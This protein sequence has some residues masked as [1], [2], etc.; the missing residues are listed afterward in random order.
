MQEGIGGRLPEFR[1]V[2]QAVAILA[3]ERREQVELHLAA[4]G[5]IAVLPAAD[6]RRTVV[7]VVLGI[8]PQRRQ[9]GTD[10]AGLHEGIAVEIAATGRS[11]ERRGGKRCVR[12]CIS[13]WAPYH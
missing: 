10:H 1:M 9:G 13:R 8:E 11:E 4:A 12:P 3:I 7:A 5:G 6:C 2:E